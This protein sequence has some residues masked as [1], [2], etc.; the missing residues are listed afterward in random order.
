V[1]ATRRAP[2][3]QLEHQVGKGSLAEIGAQARFTRRYRP[4]TNGKAERF[5]RTLVEEWAYQP[6]DSN[7]DRAAALP[8]WLHTYNHHRCDTAIGGQPPIT[9]VNNPTGSYT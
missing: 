4:Q 1:A 7:D 2:A 3:D 6:F 8:A 5:N 9:R